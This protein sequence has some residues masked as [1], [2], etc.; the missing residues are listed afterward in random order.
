MVDGMA[1]LADVT[2]CVCVM[3]VAQQPVVKLSRPLTHTA[4]QP[5]TNKQTNTSTKLRQQIT[6]V[7]CHPGVVR[8]EL[9]RYLV[10]DIPSFAKASDWLIL[11]D[12]LTAPSISLL[13]DAV[14]YF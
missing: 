5:Q 3:C 10:D 9:G 4:P 11:M 2:V 8:T 13:S 14:F 7:C 12:R 6:T 1:M